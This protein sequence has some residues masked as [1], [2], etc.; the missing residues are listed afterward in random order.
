MADQKIA[1]LT[2]IGRLLTRCREFVDVDCP[3]CGGYH[4]T[5]KFMKNGFGKN[6]N[7]QHKTPV[8]GVYMFETFFLFVKLCTIV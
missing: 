5:V 1:A 8:D 4:R 7:M 6:V 2:D 3:A